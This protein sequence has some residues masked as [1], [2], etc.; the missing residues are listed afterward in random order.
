MDKIIKSLPQDE[1]VELV[2]EGRIPVEEMERHESSMEGC[3]G[4]LTQ[5]I[6]KLQKGIVVVVGGGDN[7]FRNLIKSLT[8]LSSKGYQVKELFDATPKGLEK[9]GKD[10]DVAI[11]Y[12]LFLSHLKWKGNRRETILR[13]LVRIGEKLLIII[14]AFPFEVDKVRPWIYDAELKLK[15]FEWIY[16]TR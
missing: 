7:I 9:Y 8:Q 3:V 12:P 1:V 15:D 6:E 4:L 13:D 14:P 10:I 11:I 2:T 5:K 16:L